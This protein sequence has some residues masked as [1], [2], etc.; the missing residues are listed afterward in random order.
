MTIPRRLSRFYLLSMLKHDMDFKQVQV[1]EFLWHFL[2]KWW[3]FRRIWS[4]FRPS[5]LQEKE[6]KKNLVTFFTGKIRF[7]TQY[8]YTSG[9]TVHIF[10]EEKGINGN[11][12]R[13]RFFSPFLFPKAWSMAYL[14]L[15]VIWHKYTQHKCKR[16]YRLRYMPVYG[17]KGI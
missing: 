5:C 13:E 4:Y 10:M 2:R 8:L 9:Y 15:K 12:L 7:S 1:M 11:K 16:R 14:E 17:T 6:M 3:D